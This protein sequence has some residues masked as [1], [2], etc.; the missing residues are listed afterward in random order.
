M[1]PGLREIKGLM[2]GEADYLRPLGGLLV[3]I[4]YQNAA[5]ADADV[6][7]RLAIEPDAVAA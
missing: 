5:L 3:Q 1:M 2:A 4:L 7:Q 6:S